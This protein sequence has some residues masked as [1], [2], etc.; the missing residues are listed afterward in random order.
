MRRIY[1]AIRDPNWNTIP[2]QMSD[3]QVERGADRFQVSFRAVHTAGPLEFEWRATI[4][5]ARDGTIRYAMDGA[6]HSA[7]RYCRIGF[8][9]LHPIRECA[10]RPYRAQTPQGEVRGELPLSVGPQMIVNGF[11]APLFPSFSNL[12]IALESGRELTFEF[13]GDLFE[14]EDQRNWTDGSFKT[15]CTPLALGYPHQAAEGQAF[16]QAV[17]IRA[18]PLPP[19]EASPAP[20]AV[21]RPARLVLG[22]RL[23]RGLPALGFGLPSGGPA[24]SA[25]EVDRLARL[26]PAHLRAEVHFGDE[27]WPVGLASALESAR[28]IGSPLE[29]ALFLDGDEERAAQALG[30]LSERLEGVAVG[31]A[32]VFHEAEASRAATSPQWVA[33]AQVALRKAL[34]GASIGGGTNGN[35]AE[36]HRAWPDL[37]GWG[38]V[39]YTLNP[40]VHAFDERSLVEAL[41]A[42]ADTVR[43]AREHSGELPVCVSSV[44]LKPPFN[45]A[46]R[47]EEAPPAPDQLPP[48]VD[49][50]QMSLFAAVWTLGSIGALA[51]GGAA[52]V[53]YYET[54]GW[55]GLMESGAGCPLPARFRSLPGMVFPVY[56][57]FADLAEAGPA[58]LIEALPSDP[59]CVQG[60]ALGGAVA[61]HV[62]LA[63]MLPMPQPVTVG[64][65]PA[66]WARVRRL[67][68]ASADLAALEPE[69][70][71]SLSEAWRLAGGEVTLVLAPYELV[72]LRVEGGG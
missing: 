20:G 10:G 23:G 36:L 17:T 65:L 28:R 30:E 71:R 47:E 63:N 69:R 49:P 64:P 70:F 67:N 35:F 51:A 1:V 68:E 9:V 4:S 22:Q 53:T 39:S 46:A 5:G 11:E 52:S 31:R 19:A 56:H 42:Q 34:P 38:C 27:D 61:W 14:M 8:C 6:A 33:L 15:Y 40:Q 55:R 12:T 7:F 62:W 59:L 43:T 44:T 25:R 32:L 3:R 60:L 66:G 54:I 24:L 57:V 58:E 48:S 26:R 72:S 18:V 21:E 29:L 16:H 45:Q 13:E 50:R 37:H 2:G 41:E